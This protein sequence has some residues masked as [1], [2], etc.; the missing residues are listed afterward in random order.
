MNRDDNCNKPTMVSELIEELQAEIYFQQ[1]SIFGR[2]YNNNMVLFVIITI[3][4]NKSEAKAGFL[5]RR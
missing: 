3:K 2:D 5:Y 4:E 1:L